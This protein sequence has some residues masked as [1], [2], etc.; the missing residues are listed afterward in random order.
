MEK[1]LTGVRARHESHTNSPSE[2]DKT[3]HRFDLCPVT[4]NLVRRYLR[5]EHDEPTTSQIASDV[6]SPDSNTIKSTKPD[7]FLTFASEDLPLARKVFSFLRQ[8][9][10]SVF[11]SQESIHQGNFG[12]AID[13]ALKEAKSLVVVGTA[14]DYFFKPW[15]R[16]EW[17]SFHNDILGGRKPWDTP[18]VAFA[19]R[20]D[21]ES[22]PRPLMFRQVVECDPADP[23]PSL[24]RLHT[25]LG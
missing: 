16:Y 18:L 25:L 4:R 24:E 3:K 21:R 6:P 11:F 22:M 19:S 9:G 10:R 2:Y 13:A 15:V 5:L 12:D 14:A 23:T 8:K 17:Q 20:I 7:V 1:Y